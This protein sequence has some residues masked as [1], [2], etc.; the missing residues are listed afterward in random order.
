LAASLPDQLNQA[1][2][3]NLRFLLDQENTTCIT[4][5]QRLSRALLHSYNQVQ[6]KKGQ[7]SW[8]T[9]DI[10]PWSSWLQRLWSQSL[11]KQVSPPRLLNQWQSR[12]LWESIIEKYADALLNITSTADKAMQCRE[13]LTGWQV[14]LTNERVRRAMLST[15]DSK[16]WL[17]WHEAYLS[18][19]RE[20]HW[21]DSQ[22]LAKKLLGLIPD[23]DI[24]AGHRFLIAGFDELAPAQHALTEA[25]SQKGIEFVKIKEDAS[26]TDPDPTVYVLPDEEAELYA[27][28]RWARQCYESGWK[29]GQDPITVVI[30]S[31]ARQREDIER[32]FR[33]VFYPRDNLQALDAGPFHGQ[34]VRREC[35]FNISLGLPLLQ[36]PLIG[37][38]FDILTMCSGTFDQACL[39]RVTTSRF[40]TYSENVK[41]VQCHEL[42]IFLRAFGRV[43]WTLPS[44]TRQLKSY[45][46]DY[47]AKRF[48]SLLEVASSLPDRALLTDWV[49]SVN[50]LFNAFGW[51]ADTL[52]GGYEKQ[53]MQAWDEVLSTLI[54]LQDVVGKKTSFSQTLARL[55]QI[56]SGQIFQAGTGD[57]PVQVMGMI[58][59]SGMQFSALRICG[60]QDR[61]WPPAPQPNPFIP[62]YLQTEFDMPHSSSRRELEYAQWQLERLLASSKTVSLS[63]AAGNE[64][65]K[66]NAS[67]LVSHLKSVAIDPSP[68]REQ[69]LPVFQY[70]ADQEGPSVNQQ[71]RDVNTFVLRDQS[72]CP[73]RAYARH[74]LLATAPEIPEPGI[75]PRTKG[76]LLH[77]VM[78]RLWKHW[79]DQKTF[80]S[81]SDDSIDKTVNDVIQDVMDKSFTSSSRV[82]DPMMNGS[83]FV[84]LEKDRLY[85]LVLDWLAI[86]RQRKPFRVIDPESEQNYELAGLRLRM[87]I[88]RMDELSDG[89]LCIIDYKS[90]KANPSAWCGERP[91]E[92]QVPLYSLAKQ[93]QVSAVAFARLLGGETALAG[94]TRDYQLFSENER[95]FRDMKQLPI[96]R[97][98]AA[99][100]EYRDWESLIVHWQTV[101]LNIAANYAKGDAQ[102][103][104]VNADSTCTYCDIK[105]V[106][107]IFESETHIQENDS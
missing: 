57:V 48:S 85:R 15:S 5:T 105:P 27:A 33:E 8:D 81:L 38:L 95:L 101:L 70:M 25:F 9:P 34:G 31:I 54:Q 1:T 6:V 2:E 87:R 78:E 3:S 14:D 65:E 68:R 24:D 45:R 28:A 7:M 98:N 84:E 93:Q 88:D 75:D 99:C 18:R 83:A 56:A 59:A 66:Y 74:R 40:M 21:I 91:E 4:S 79:Q 49:R 41:I 20:M 58:E 37:Y 12:S 80:L 64:D 29:T 82:I 46:D 44:V 72:Q 77:Q 61:D 103:D 55:K 94:M 67:P 16:A 17:Q 92:P 86:E 36:E 50:L 47:F 107:R 11:V 104:P 100:S 39:S 42:D 71:E 60:M 35:I 102:V 19:L 13:L 32:V 96:K 52:Q 22:D 53:V 26:V 51:S 90:G 76:I 73:F 63:Y 106:C 69:A 97:K 62:V 89:S 10:L 30:P 23:I 43:K